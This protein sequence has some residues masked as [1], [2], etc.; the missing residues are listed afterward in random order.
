MDAKDTKT[1]KS[2]VRVGA[3]ECVL[4]LVLKNRLLNK[5]KKACAPEAGPEVNGEPADSGLHWFCPD[6]PCSC[7][8]THPP[9]YSA[10]SRLGPLENN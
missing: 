10:P 1:T 9:G 4:L 2:W 8:G 7:C 3:Y 5:R 6:S